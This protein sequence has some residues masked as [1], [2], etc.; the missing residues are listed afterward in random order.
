MYFNKRMTPISAFD[1]Y[2]SLF[3]FFRILKLNFVLNK[4]QFNFSISDTFALSPNEQMKKKM[5]TEV[6]LYDATRWGRIIIKMPNAIEPK[7]LL[8]ILRS[9]VQLQISSSQV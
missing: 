1:N 2:F 6:K 3:I 4:L 9:V 8:L 5:F 7:L